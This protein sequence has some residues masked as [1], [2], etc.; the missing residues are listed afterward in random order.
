MRDRPA[1]P[2]ATLVRARELACEAALHHVYTGNVHGLEGETTYCHGCQTPLIERDWYE[3][4]AYRLDAE[5]RCPS[6]QT[7]CAGH[8]DAAPGEW[9]RK[10]PPVVIG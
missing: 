7:V 5:G 8:F 3:I 1:T 10:R 9:G 6:C 4:R 2:K